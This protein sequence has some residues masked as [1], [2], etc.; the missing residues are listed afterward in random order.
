MPEDVVAHPLLRVAMRPVV[1]PDHPLASLGRPDF[2][3]A[4]FGWCRMPEHLV[5]GALADGRLV[6]LEI[7]DDTAP[8]EGLAIFAAHRRDRAL[9]PAGRWLLDALR[10]NLAA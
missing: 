6:A 10:R 3:V 1:A 8:S 9:G 5:A 2:L 7:E 4:G